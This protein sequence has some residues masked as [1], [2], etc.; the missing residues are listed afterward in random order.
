MVHEIGSYVAKNRFGYD[1]EPISPINYDT[2]K[3]ALHG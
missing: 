1:G 3:G 2:M